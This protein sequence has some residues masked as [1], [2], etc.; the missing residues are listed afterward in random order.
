MANV[1]ASATRMRTLV[2]PAFLGRNLKIPSLDP[3]STSSV[4]RIPTSSPVLRLC[5]SPT[6]WSFTVKGLFTLAAMVAVEASA[7][8]GFLCE[9]APVAQPAAM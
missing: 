4:V 8:F 3:F 2:F 6:P 5:V 1:F 7:G 9:E